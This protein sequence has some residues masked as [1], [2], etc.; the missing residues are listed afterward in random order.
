MS[1]ETLPVDPYPWKRPIAWVTWAILGSTIAVFCL[2][3]YDA[4]AHGGR[5]IVGDTLSFSP[6][7]FADHRYWT[8]VTYA[9]A[10]AASMFGDPG[11]F[12]L[13][14]ASN[15]IF[16]ICL[17][18]AL[19]ELIGHWNYLGL[20]VGGAIFSALVWFFFNRNGDAEQGIIG[21]SGAVFALIGAAGTAAP[22]ARVTVYLFYILPLRM[23][24]GVM[25]VVICA[26]EIGII[27][28][29]WMPEVAHSAHLGG[30]A[31]GFLYVLII[32]R[33]LRRNLTD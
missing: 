25:A 27:L 29:G 10:H 31:F 23:S 12:W 17:G 13:H 22:R 24:L 5:D 19:E 6:Q 8:L 4:R 28:L 3:L 21:A 7:A 18:P 20:Y 32:R 33:G 11:L 14:I 1:T 16:L 26:V 9:W 15:M 30:A 2:Q